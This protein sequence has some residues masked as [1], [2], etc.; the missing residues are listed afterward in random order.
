MP[1]I[2]LNADIVPGT[3]AAGFRI[4]QTSAEIQLAEL[5]Y[6]PEVIWHESQGPLSIAIDE[7]KGWLSCDVR[8][9]TMPERRGTF[10]WYNHGAVNLQFNADGLLYCISVWQG[11]AGRFADAIRIGDRL[12]KVLAF[13]DV[14]HDSGDEAHYPVEESPIRGIGFFAEDTPLANSPDQLIRGISVQDWSLQ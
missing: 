6:Y 11:Y 13:T 10:L 12:D 2:D 5:S 14:F 9:L 3:S 7:T 8:K 4:G 1:M